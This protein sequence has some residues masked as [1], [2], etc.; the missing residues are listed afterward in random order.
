MKAIK[1][2]Y[3]VLLSLVFI[4]IT[5]R[6]CLPFLAKH[7]VN[8]E[9]NFDPAYRGSVQSVGIH[10]WRSAY[11]VA[12][13]K[14]ERVEGQKTFPLLAAKRIDVGLSWK[15]LIHGAVVAKVKVND[16]VANLVA[17]PKATVQPV[18]KKSEKKDSKVALGSGTR[19]EKKQELADWH[20]V[21]KD[22]I[23][24]DI[25]QLIIE[26]KSFHFR[27]ITSH[28]K[29]DVYLD[30]LKVE[31]KNLTNSN[32]VATNL[33]GTID[34]KARAMKSG[35]LN[36]QIHINPIVSPTEMKADLKLI[37]LNLVELNE[38]FTAYGKFDVKQG[39]FDLFSEVAVANNKIEGYA[40]PLIKHL[41]VAKFSEDKKKGV[42]HAF[43]EQIVGSIAAIFKNFPKDRQAAKIPFKGRLDDPKIDIWSTL[44]SILKNMFITPIIPSMDSGVKL[45]DLK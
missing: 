40:K 20:K 16:L 43:W 5:F 4:L 42:I 41:E 44:G 17:E 34:I 2:K 15:D 32:K 11:S 7:Y 37:H 9:L 23:P 8:K 45:K 13:F 27:D 24:L 3:Y 28:P 19:Q 1:K 35:D 36:L 14:I 39:E 18:T 30:E 33:F 38:L 22:L 10:L 31:G 6:L 26:G 21:F 25:S 29:I 12:N